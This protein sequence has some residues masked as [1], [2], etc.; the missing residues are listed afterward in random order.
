M[1]WLSLAL[2]KLSLHLFMTYIIQIEIKDEYTRLGVYNVEMS[3][4]DYVTE[5]AC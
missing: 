4:K 5:F 1:Q 2:C 3:N